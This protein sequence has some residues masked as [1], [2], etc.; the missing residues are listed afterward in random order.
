MAPDRWTLILVCALAAMAGCSRPAP[1]PTGPAGAT[2]VCL[3]RLQWWEGEV[4]HSRSDALV[5]RSSGDAAADMRR[6]QAAEAAAAGQPDLVANVWHAG[7]LT[8]RE[9]NFVDGPSCE[10]LPA[11]P[12]AR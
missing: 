10:Q 9:L 3:R 4:A 11:S 7:W 8:D 1:A 12:G 5:V 2:G 6:L